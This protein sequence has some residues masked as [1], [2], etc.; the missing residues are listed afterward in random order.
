R[1]DLWT[2]HRTGAAGHRFTYDRIPPTL[3]PSGAPPSIVAI[4]SLTD[5]AHVFVQRLLMYK[6]ANV[7]ALPAGAAVFWAGHADGRSFAPTEIDAF[8][9]LASRLAA[10]HAAAEPRSLSLARLAPL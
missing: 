6:V 10:A 8:G 4:E 7:L 9:A 2:R 1:A 3:R 5:P